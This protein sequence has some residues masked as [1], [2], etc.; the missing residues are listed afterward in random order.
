MERTTDGWKR[1]KE[2]RRKKKK[3]MAGT[4]KGVVSMA[5]D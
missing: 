5:A 4:E 2:K 1:M 3:K